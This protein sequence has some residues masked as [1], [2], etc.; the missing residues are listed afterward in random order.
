[1][2]RVLQP[3]QGDLDFHHE[4]GEI[5]K[6]T[7]EIAG[8]VTRRVHVSTLPPEV[9]EAQI[10]NIISIYGEVKKIH[11]EIWPQAYRFEVKTGVRLVD[12]SLRKHIPSHVKIEGHRALVSYEGQPMKCSRC[13]EQ[14]HQINDCPGRK[15]PG[16]QQT[17]HDGNSWANKV[18]RGTEKAPSDVNNGTNNIPLSSTG[19]AHQVIELQSR[20]PDQ[21]AHEKQDP[22]NNHG[23]PI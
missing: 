19:E 18:K 3:I 7:I 10:T 6:L 4:N 13:S 15:L 22:M 9:T 8:V 12:I 23:V 14:G 17:S 2:M 20:S 1:M 11:D 21:D 16:S 5:S